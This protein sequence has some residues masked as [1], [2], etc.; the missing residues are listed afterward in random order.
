MEGLYEVSRMKRLRR[1]L[2]IPALLLSCLLP[3][4]VRADLASDIRAILTEKLIAKDQVSIEIIRLG[5]SPSQS[6][7]IYQLKSTTPRIP[8]SNLKLTTTATA[9]NKLGSDFQFK[10][11][12]ARRGNDLAIIG[13][14]DPTLGDVEMLKKVG[15]GVDTVFKAWAETLKARGITEVNNLFVD[16][17]IF[18]EQ[19]MHPNWPPEQQHL[20]YVA[21]VGG[22][23]LNA[24]CVDFYLRPSG[25]NQM[26]DYRTEP[27]TNYITVRNTCVSGNQDGLIYLSR[28]LGTNDIILKGEARSANE[29]PASVTIHDPPMFAGTVLAEV[30]RA[31]G[32]KVTGSVQRDRTIRESLASA[33]S[34]NAAPSTKP[35]SEQ[36]TAIA[37]HATPIWMVLNRAHKD[38]MNLYAESLCKRIGAAATGTSGSWES[39]TAAVGSFLASLGVSREEFNLDDGCGLSKK[40]TISVNALAKVLEHEYHSKDQSAWIG[41]LAVAATDGTLKSRFVGTDLK[42]RVFAKSGFVTGVRSLSGYLRA[43]DGQFYAFAILMNGVNEAEVNPKTLQEKIVAAVDRGGGRV[44]SGE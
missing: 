35:A 42:G 23:N 18:D 14:G 16:D 41:S 38:S 39:G 28:Q 31:N 40:N 17:S 25:F 6:E 10:T 32:I 8:A 37:V 7:V 11:T 36:W 24:N 12:L 19:F 15:W 1:S 3:G 4:V 22:I 20:R 2:C 5:A 26:V 21:Q 44:A 33:T 13:D 9:L 43:R 34:G 29:E 27:A 30:L